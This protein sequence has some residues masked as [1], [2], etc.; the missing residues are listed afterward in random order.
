MPLLKNNTELMNKANEI[1]HKYLNDICLKLNVNIDYDI[2]G[3]IGK[4]YRRQDEIGT[5]YCLTIDFQTLE[6]NT[7]T[8]RD[9]NTMEQQRIDI[10]K[11]FDHVLERL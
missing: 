10:N 9:R 6:D 11:L 7:L 1:Y 5:P 3:S 4:R 2:N 8:I